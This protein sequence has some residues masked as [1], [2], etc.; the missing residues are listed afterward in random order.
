VAFKGD[1][2]AH[3]YQEG[4]S[5]QPKQQVIIDYEPVASSM[6]TSNFAAKQKPDGN[7]LMYTV[8][9]SSILPAFKESLQG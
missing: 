9:T 5:A 7:A 2:E 4:L 6:I 3:V 1:S 8:A